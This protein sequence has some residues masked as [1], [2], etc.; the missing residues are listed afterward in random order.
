MLSRL[1][2]DIGQIRWGRRLH[3]RAVCMFGCIHVYS[4]IF[5]ADMASELV[6]ATCNGWAAM[7]LLMVVD[8]EGTGETGNALPFLVEHHDLRAAYEISTVR[9]PDAA[10]QWL[11]S[12]SVRRT[13]HHIP[14]PRS[15]QM[16]CR[17]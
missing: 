15:L 8:I 11:A 17:W 10:C 6:G 13:A 9:E 16:D 4:V 3:V 1:F 5:E 7:S 2:E 14:P 12:G